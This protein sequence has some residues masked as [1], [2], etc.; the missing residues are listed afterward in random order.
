MSAKM[1]SASRKTKRIDRSL[2]TVIP[3]EIYDQMEKEIADE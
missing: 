2:N 3:S 1:F